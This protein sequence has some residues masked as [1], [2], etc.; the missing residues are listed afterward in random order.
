MLPASPQ[1]LPG[2][3]SNEKDRKQLKAQEC[4]V[5][6]AAEAERRGRQRAAQGPCKHQ[7]PCVGRL[8]PRS[9]Q[10]GRN[11]LQ[12]FREVVSNRDVLQDA[13]S[14]IRPQELEPLTLVDEL[15]RVAPLRVSRF[16]DI[17]RPES[18]ERWR[19]H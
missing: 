5:R 7:Q 19:S 13:Y 2:G 11:I 3:G 12:A 8:P 14:S 17:V 18:A 15:V 4:A 1:Q 16:T 9:M 6:R 10:T